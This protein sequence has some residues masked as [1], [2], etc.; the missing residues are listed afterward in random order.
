MNFNILEVNKEQADAG[1]VLD[2]RMFIIQ[3]TVF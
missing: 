2:F 3:T 1:G